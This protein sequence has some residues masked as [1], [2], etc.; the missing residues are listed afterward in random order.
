MAKAGQVAAGRQFSLASMLA[1]MVALAVLMGLA[2]IVV[3]AAM[4]LD[5]KDWSMFG[6][7]AGVAA[8]AVACVAVFVYANR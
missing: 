8:F 1:V 5:P 2:R 6:W 7:M 4:E 3:P